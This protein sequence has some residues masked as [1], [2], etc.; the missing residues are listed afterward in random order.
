[1]PYLLGARVSLALLLCA[2]AA[3]MGIH[4]AWL[5]RQQCVAFSIYYVL[6]VL[7]YRFDSIA[8]CSSVHFE[9]SRG[10]T[11]RVCCPLSDQLE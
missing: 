2:L 8:L 1:V 5:P 11:M 9:C 3:S 4:L 6:A 7:Q 10:H